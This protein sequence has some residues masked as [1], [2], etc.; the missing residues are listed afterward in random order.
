MP[1]FLLLLQRF[2]CAGFFSIESQVKPVLVQSADL[3]IMTAFQRCAETSRIEGIQPTNQGD[4]HEKIDRIGLFGIV[5]QCICAGFC[6]RA[7]GQDE[8]M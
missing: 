8:G 3:A 2:C 5:R 7:A 6:G 1:A 4:I